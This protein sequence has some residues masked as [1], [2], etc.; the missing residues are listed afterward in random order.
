M[1]P[2]PVPRRLVQL[3]VGLVLYGVT[4]ALMVR[5]GLGLNPWDVFH[6]GTSGLT[7]LSFGT[8]TILVGVVVLLAWIP[9]R[10][11]PGVGTIANVVVI[12]LAVDATLWLL[13]EPEHLAA[14]IAFLLLGIVGNGIAGGLY[15]GAGLGPG[16]RDGLMTGLVRVTGRST[17]LVRTSIE[18]TVLALGWVVGGTVGLGTVL[19]ALAV[20]PVVQLA[21]G[22]FTI[23]PRTAGE[24]AQ[25]SPS[26]P[27]NQESASP[28]SA[29]PVQ[30]GTR[31]G[32]PSALG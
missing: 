19:Y 32:A 3:L 4:M 1:I 15:I 22:W 2:R 26:S 21:L 8:M 23:R 13:P 14:R 7:G 16:P 24:G 9:L 17:R 25:P 5:S 12:G 20:G 6:E 30:P 11:R 10:Q 18:L 28:N 31:D 29:A 27:A